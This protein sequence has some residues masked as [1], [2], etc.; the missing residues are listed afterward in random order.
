ASGPVTCSSES[1]PPTAYAM[2]TPPAASATMA[3]PIARTFRLMFI[4]LPPPLS[5]GFPAP[6][7]LPDDET[8]MR[9]CVERSH[10]S[11]M[12]APVHPS[13]DEDYEADRGRAWCQRR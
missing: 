11:L 13:L 10:R 4:R 8:G 7:V 2:P 9:P 1:P 5:F 12:P 6:R 3:A